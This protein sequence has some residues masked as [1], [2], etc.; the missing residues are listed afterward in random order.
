MLSIAEHTFQ[1]QGLQEQLHYII[2]DGIIPALK[3]LDLKLLSNFSPRNWEVPQLEELQQDKW[4]GFLQDFVDCFNFIIQT[5][6]NNRALSIDLMWDSTI[7]ISFHPNTALEDESISHYNWAF[8]ATMFPEDLQREIAE[9]VIPRHPP[10]QNDVQRYVLDKYV[11]ISYSIT[12]HFQRELERHWDFYQRNYESSGWGF[13]PKQYIIDTMPPSE[14]SD[15]FVRVISG[16]LQQCSRRATRHL[17]KHA[18]VPALTQFFGLQLNKFPNSIKAWMESFEFSLHNHFVRNWGTVRHIIVTCTDTHL[19]ITFCPDGAATPIRIVEEGR[20][21]VISRDRLNVNEA[22][23]TFFDFSTFGTYRQLTWPA[24]AEWKPW[25]S[26][27]FSYT[28]DISY[29]D[30]LNGAFESW[31][32]RSSETMPTSAETENAYDLNTPG[33]IAYTMEFHEVHRAATAITSNSTALAAKS[34]SDPELDEIGD[35]SSLLNYIPDSGASQHMTPRLDDLYDVEEGL[36][37]GVIVAD[38]HVIKVTKTGKIKIRMVDD[39]GKPLVATLHQV[40]YVPGL[41]RRLFSLTRFTEQGHTVSMRKNEICLRFGE[42]QSPVTLVVHSDM[43]LASNVRVAV[44]TGSAINSGISGASTSSTQARQDLSRNATASIA[45]VLVPIELLRERMGL[46]S[47]KPF[48]AA[49]EY[50]MWAD[51]LARMEPAKNLLNVKI[52][53]IRQEARNKHPHTPATRV[54]EAVFSDILPATKS[55]GLTPASTYSAYIIFVDAYSTRPTVEGLLGSTSADVIDA[56]KQYVADHTPVSQLEINSVEKFKADAGKQFTSKEFRTYCRENKINLA[57]AAP[58]KQYQNHFAEK[59]WS[60]VHDM[61]RAMLVHARLPD[62]YLFHVIRYA[63]EVFSA[64]PIAGLFNAEGNPATP[65]ELFT[66]NKPTV[67]HFRVFG[68]PVVIKK[69]MAVVDG[70][71]LQKQTQRGVRGIF[72]GLPPN[73]KGYL[74]FIPQTRPIV[75][76]GD[77]AFDESFYSA[78]AT[79]WRPFHDA[80]ALR[81][82]ASHVPAVD[83]L[84]ETTGT[85]DSMFLQSQEGKSDETAHSF[86]DSGDDAS[87]LLSVV[88]EGTTPIEPFV[89]DAAEATPLVVDDGNLRRSTRLRRKPEKLLFGLHAMVERDWSTVADDIDFAVACAADATNINLAGNEASK[90]YPPPSSI[91]QVMALKDPELKEAW[92]KAY[93]KEIKVLID[94][95]TFSIERPQPSEVIVPT[96]ETNKVKL[97]SDGSLDKLKCRIVVRGDLQEKILNEDKWSPTASFRAMKM[98]LAD[99]ARLKVRVRQLDFIGAYLQ[100]K[101]RGRIFVRM[102][103]IY[104]ELWP[105]FKAY[106]GVPLR[107]LKS[108]YGMTQSGKNWYLELHEYL[109]SAGFVQSSVIR[110][111]YS[112]VFPDGSIV[113]V[114]DYVDDM[115]YY[116]TSVE[117]LKLFEAELKTR[118]DLDLMGQAQW[119][120]ATR[121]TQHANFDITVD[122]SRYCTSLVKRYL[123]KAGCK[124][125]TRVHVTPLPLDFIPTIDDLSTDEATSLKLQEEYNLDY[126][127]CIGALIYLA[128]TRTDII[129]SVNKLAK[130]TK[131]P[132]EN[133][134]KALIHLLRYLRDHIHLGVRYYSDIDRAPVTNLLKTHGH[135]LTDLFYAFSDSSWNDDVD[136]G[137][138]TGC[139]LV[140][141]MG[142]IVD[143]SSN[144][145]DPVALSSAEVFNRRYGWSSIGLFEM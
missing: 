48:L 4:S 102:P 36:K 112:K 23:P 141:Y 89:D 140:Y 105:E 106:S 34:I 126:A 144:L 38:G 1:Q 99:A 29:E 138:S 27:V 111:F 137:R 31:E 41:S 10:E 75:V 101:A 22:P 28:E 53:T 18:V 115:L 65:A 15:K 9:L 7:R 122:Q 46:R 67:L 8:A 37:L 121:I 47:S 120:L 20:E 5:T 87:D 130:F 3:I 129:F 97:K 136:N 56:L 125:I 95:G 108:M 133:H 86:S 64:L 123:D 73:Q 109:L 79:T 52:A 74:I 139:F 83:E 26:N 45:K 17:L 44:G 66:G 68:C 88:D 61:A 117:T 57:L 127:S 62:T 80:L 100:S 13:A 84:L 82:L 32:G 145:P 104:G 110:C 39:D 107:L 30:R 143:H 2:Q 11:T 96:M 25:S 54:G 59:T 128:L 94:S 81:P 142:G 69:H 60:T 93:K 76:S 43:T 91:R 35:P 98:F 55:G 116:G 71:P 132:G 42:A 85:I 90:F 12:D 40:M 33:G 134:L 21:H 16:K 78:I 70:K 114:L 119:Y 92:L 58:K 131:R 72:I 63:C 49:S 135:N 113:K 118:F 51:A 14:Q 6:S 103:A 77:V 50:N 19:N 124:N 24:A